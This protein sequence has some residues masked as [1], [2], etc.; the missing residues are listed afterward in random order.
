MM[1]VANRL[2]LL[3]LEVG[4]R[5]T[6]RGSAPNWGTEAHA[7]MWPKGAWRTQAGIREGRGCRPSK[8]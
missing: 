6:L 1:R 7:V 4:G 2:W 3:G 8:L 5:Q